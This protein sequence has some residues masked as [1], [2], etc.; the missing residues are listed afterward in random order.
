MHTEGGAHSNRIRV[1]HIGRAYDLVT[2]LLDDRPEL[3]LFDGESDFPQD[4]RDWLQRMAK[5]EPH[6][7]LI[8]SKPFAQYVG[9]CEDRLRKSPRPKGIVVFSDHAN[10]KGPVEAAGFNFVRYGQ[11]KEL[12]E[13]IRYASV[14]DGKPPR[15]LD[16]RNDPELDPEDE[17]YQFLPPPAPSS[18]APRDEPPFMFDCGSGNLYRGQVIVDTLRAPTR[19][20]LLTILLRQRAARP[21]DGFVATQEL[22]RQISP[23]GDHGTIATN[24]REVE[25]FLEKSGAPGII[26]SKRRSLGGPRGYTI[27]CDVVRFKRA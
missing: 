23:H 20:A 11:L 19:V 24:K 2:A 16:R 13:S 3:E 12:F 25:A 14:Q 26:V 18:P 7:W 15:V 27:R 9:W 8:T 5:Y 6:V 21:D 4:A 17:K 10:D 1:F 22:V